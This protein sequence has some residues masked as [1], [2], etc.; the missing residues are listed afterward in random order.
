MIP[1][2]FPNSLV[3]RTESTSKCLTSGFFSFFYFCLLNN[4]FRENVHLPLWR[5]RVLHPPSCHFL[6]TAA[7]C[8]LSN[9]LWEK[10]HLPLWRCR[11]LLPT[12]CHFLQTAAVCLLPYLLREKVHTYLCGGAGYFFPLLAI[13]SWRRRSASC[14]IS[15]GKRFTLTSVVVPGTSS[16]SLPFSPDG[17]ALPPAL[18]PPDFGQSSSCR[19]LP[20]PPLPLPH[21]PPRSHPGVYFLWYFPKR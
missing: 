18:S 1:V 9:L 19:P 15:S 5:C 4:L 2:S 11:A 14:L 12:P 20:L 13:F 3:I 10:F 21:H 8:L 17:D 6:L 16:H 7:L